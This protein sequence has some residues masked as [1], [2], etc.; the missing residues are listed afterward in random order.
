MAESLIIRLR[1]D[2]APS[3]MVCNED[4]QVLVNP[5]EGELVQAVPLAVGRRVVVIV[6]AGAAMI[7]DSRAPERDPR[8]FT[9]A[10]TP[11]SVTRP[12][13]R[14]APPPSAGIIMAPV[15]MR[16]VATAADDTTEFAAQRSVPATPPATG[17]KA[18]LT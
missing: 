12:M 13:P 5:A 7:I 17:P 14:H 1:D 9:A 15:S 4:G 18:S 11:Y 3:W 10:S 8:M 6:P 2:A 16:R